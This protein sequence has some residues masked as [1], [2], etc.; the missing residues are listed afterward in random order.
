MSKR[1][2]SLGRIA[3]LHCLERVQ[4]QHVQIAVRGG[5]TASSGRTSLNL[6]RQSKA[7]APQTVDAFSRCS[8]LK[9]HCQD[10]N[11]ALSPTCAILC[12]SKIK[13]HCGSSLPTADEHL[14]DAPRFLL[15]DVIAPRRMDEN[16]LRPTIMEKHRKSFPLLVEELTVDAPKLLKKNGTVTPP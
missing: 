9:T 5:C 1:M 3:T 15:K 8:E 4:R 13:E 14:V 2:N 6:T 11:C 10:H 7:K 12:Q 16:M